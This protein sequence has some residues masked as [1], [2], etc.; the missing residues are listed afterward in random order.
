LI[1]ISIDSSPPFLPISGT[2]GALNASRNYTVS[3][4]CSKQICLQSL[5][6]ETSNGKKLQKE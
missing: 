1:L 2:H 4:L 5:L 3:F 6:S